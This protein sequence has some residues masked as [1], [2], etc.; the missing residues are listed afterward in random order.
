MIYPRKR[1]GRR[2]ILANGC[3][4]SGMPGGQR[5]TGRVRVDFLSGSRGGSVS[6]AS[7]LVSEPGKSP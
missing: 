1:G 7:M 4:A 2:S 6:I 3:A 5:E